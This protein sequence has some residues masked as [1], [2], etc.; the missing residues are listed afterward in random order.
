V[1]DSVFM[2]PVLYTALY[3]RSCG[4]GGAGASTGSGAAGFAWAGLAGAGLVCVAAGLV[5]DGRAGGFWVW[6]CAAGDVTFNTRARTTKRPYGRGAGRSMIH[7]PFSRDER[8]EHAQAPSFGRNGVVGPFRTGS[9]F[10]RE[11]LNVSTALK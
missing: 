7:L 8:R 3:L 4:G 11:N 9:Q 2:S 1:S 6:L 5:V 10:E